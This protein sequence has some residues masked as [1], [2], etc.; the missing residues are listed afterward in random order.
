MTQETTPVMTTLLREAAPYIRSYSGKKAVII[1]SS[2]SFAPDQLISIAQDIAL[3]HTLNLQVLVILAPLLVPANI[4][5]DSV[6]SYTSF[7]VNEMQAQHIGLANQLLTRLSVGIHNATLGQTSIPAVVGHFVVA[8]PAGIINGIDQRQL[9][10]IRKIKQHDLV[11]LLERQFVVVTTAFGA[12]PSGE[13]YHVPPLE[14]ALAI[15]QA[16]EAEKIIV[17]GESAMH[18]ESGKVLREWR[19]NLENKGEM[20]SNYQQACAQLIRQALLNGIPRVHILP[21]RQQGALV[22]ELYSRDGCGTMATLERY[23]QIRMAEPDDIN[24]IAMLIAPLESQGVLIKRPQEQL[25]LDLPHFWVV[26]RDQTIIGCARLELHDNGYA[27]LACFVVDTAYQGRH[28]GSALLEHI[29][30]LARS[31]GAH[32][33]FVLTTQTADWFVER[34][35]KPTALKNLPLEKQALYNVQRNS[36][37]FMRSL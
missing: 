9:G 35:F 4:A 15:A 11:Q 8:K 30:E 37:I 24:G 32:S 5:V 20:Q 16:I 22:Q 2:P 19:Q 12:S 18:S 36:K 29:L 31:R 7:A 3:L 26:Q 21:A 27:E 28:L 10:R 25:E 34:D 6:Q 17:L 33:L 13:L 23:Q 1:L 14:Q